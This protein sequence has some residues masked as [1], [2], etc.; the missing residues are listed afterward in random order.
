MKQFILVTDNKGHAKVINVAHVE[1]VT[2][3]EDGTYYVEMANAEAS[4]YS[5][6]LVK[7]FITLSKAEGER[8]V[9]EITDDDPFHDRLLH[10]LRNIYELMRSRL[11]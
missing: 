7:P 8:L 9:R 3:D 1:T 6:N 11:H 4:E 5:D 2:I 10:V